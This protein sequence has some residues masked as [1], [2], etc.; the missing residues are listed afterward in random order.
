[1]WIPSSMP[2]PCGTPFFN[3]RRSFG[4]HIFSPFNFESQ[5]TGLF[6]EVTKKAD[7]NIPAGQE[8]GFT[9]KYTA[10]SPSKFSATKNGTDCTA[11]V[12]DTG[13]GL[14]FKLKADETIRIDFDADPSFRCEVTEDDSSKL[15]GITGTGGTADMTAKKFTSTSSAARVTFTNGTEPPPPPPDEPDP[16]KA[17]LFKRDANTNKGVGP[18]TFKFS[19]VTNGVYEFDTNASGELETIQWWDPTEKAGKYIKPGEYAVSEIVPPPNYES[20]TEVQQIKLELDADGN[21]IPAG[22]LVFKNL[23]NGGC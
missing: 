10:G 1:M 22:P 2:G 11:Q 3:E 20:T 7:E 5:P 8:W 23:S 9:V 4:L 17:I 13:S 16:G 14:K 15:T 12:T 21:P 18:A 19:S 6:L